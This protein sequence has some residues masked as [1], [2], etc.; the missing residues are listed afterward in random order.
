[1]RE[2]RREAVTKSRREK[3][4]ANALPKTGLGK[5]T[6]GEI[7]LEKRAAELPLGRMC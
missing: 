4:G 2:K 5:K 7:L 3:K 1:M 6:E